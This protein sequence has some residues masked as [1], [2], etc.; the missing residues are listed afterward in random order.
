[1]LADVQAPGVWALADHESD[2]VHAHMFRILLK[3]PCHSGS[4]LLTGV[5]F[6][7]TEPAQTAAL[8][9]AVPGASE[10]AEAKCEGGSGH[11]R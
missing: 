4:T 5:S 11:N 7:I 8:T 10:A 3:K 9:S 6:I 1:M 2:C